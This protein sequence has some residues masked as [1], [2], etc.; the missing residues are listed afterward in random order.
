MN[1]TWPWRCP[2]SFMAPS[3]LGCN[4]HGIKTR[5]KAGSGSRGCSVWAAH[6][7]L[8]HPPWAHYAG[9][10]ISVALAGTAVTAQGAA[11][12]CQT[13]DRS[14]QAQQFKLLGEQIKMLLLLWPKHF[15]NSSIWVKARPSHLGILQDKADYS[16]WIALS[17]DILLHR[18]DLFLSLPCSYPSNDF[19]VDYC[20]PAY[21]WFTLSFVLHYGSSFEGRI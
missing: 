21:P 7:A 1:C 9:G 17:Q 12:Q 10:C 15:T 8:S 16:S 5:I 2:A 20:I 13:L 11:V 18:R 3:V 6:R 4:K 14:S 19:P